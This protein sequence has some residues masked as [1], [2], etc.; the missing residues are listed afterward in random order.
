M[1]N[2]IQEQIKKK[3]T[4]DKIKSPLPKKINDLTIAFDISTTNTGYAILIDGKP[5]KFSNGMP[6]F[7]FTNMVKQDTIGKNGKEIKPKNRVYS[8]YGN[9]MFHGSFEKI[10]NIA[11]TIYELRHLQDLHFAEKKAGRKGVEIRNINLV[12]EVSEIPNGK[13]GATSQNITSVRKLALYVGMVAY[14]IFDMLTLIMPSFKEKILVK[15]ISPSEWQ[16][17]AGFT[18]TKLTQQQEIVK[19]GARWSKFQSLERANKILENWGYKPTESD[20]LA[21]ALNIAT[22]SNEVLDSMQVRARTS[23]KANNIRR[24]ESNIRKIS[25]KITEYQSKALLQKNDFIDNVLWAINVDRNKLDKKEKVKHTKYVKYDLEDVRLWELEKFFTPAQR[26][27]Y[28]EFTERKAKE[29]E[30]IVSI[31]GAKIN[32]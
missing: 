22:L 28:L 32:G 21:D 15:M 4:Q 17:K 29:Q 25:T 19:Y 14:S 6:S 10:Q 30:L 13:F 20:D 8:T 7:G 3:N 2:N 23:G 18:K 11:T 5:F 31:R 1:N 24:I 26:R 12:F 27:K 9:R 16:L